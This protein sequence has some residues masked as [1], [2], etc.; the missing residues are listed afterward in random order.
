M[1]RLNNRLLEIVV[2][3]YNRSSILALSLRELVASIEHCQEDV[4]LRVVDNCSTDDTFAIATSY[5]RNGL[6]T[7]ERNKANIGLI[8]NIAKCIHSSHARWVWVFGD[9]DHILSFSLPFLLDALRKLPDDVVFARALSA[10]LDASGFITHSESRS[11]SPTPIVIHDPGIQITR[12]GSIH[13]LAFISQLLIN[14]SYWNQQYYE[15]IYAGTDLYTFVLVLLRQCRYNKA[16]ELNFHI[17]VATDRGDRSYYTPNMCV[18][19]LTEYTRYEALVFASL[20]PL[21]AKKILAQGRHKLLWLRIVSCFKLIGNN[22]SYRIT[23]KDPISYLCCYKSPYLLDVIIIRL[24]AL[25]ARLPGV[26]GI[27]G[28]VYAYFYNRHQAL[29]S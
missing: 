18:A 1:T 10:K 17:V 27:Y 15:R 24:M 14:P 4:S 20:G 11:D 29:S 7:Y 2:P 13:D 22:D 9:D 21:K 23:G 8:N 5:A 26:R 16:A 19:R 3:T 12:V 6:L 28:F 25:A